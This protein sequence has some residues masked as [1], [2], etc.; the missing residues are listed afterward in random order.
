LSSKAGGGGH[1]SRRR[2][3][4]GE[5]V[6]YKLTIAVRSWSDGRNTLQ[7][8]LSHLAQYIGTG[9]IQF[10]DAPAT[11]E[12]Y[13]EAFDVDMNKPLYGAPKVEI[14]TG[15][16]QSDKRA[17]AGQGSRK[18]AELD[19]EYHTNAQT[20]ADIF[21]SL[22]R[23]SPFFVKLKASP[24]LADDATLL[25]L[26]HSLEQWAHPFAHTAL[27]LPT[28]TKRW[29]RQLELM[30][31]W[32]GR[33]LGIPDAKLQ[34]TDP[35]RAMLHGRPSGR[36]GESFRERKAERIKARTSRRRPLDARRAYSLV[37]ASGLLTTVHEGDLLSFIATRDGEK[38]EVEGRLLS[39][40]AGMVS[41]EEEGT[42]S[43]WRVPSRM[44]TLLST[45]AASRTKAE[46][47][48]ERKAML[49]MLTVEKM[50]GSSATV[51]IFR[52]VVK[53]RNRQRMGSTKLCVT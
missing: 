36:G 7:H 49:E 48:A 14:Q 4:K 17:A 21:V 39:V 27:K 18:H 25:L 8:E 2:T 41:L 22:Q 19:T 53:F 13:H 26:A 29:K 42:D 30:F 9:L 50:I 51:R 6:P 45:E 38:E 20:W 15:H 33:R 10:A 40:R 1:F 24:E 11:P 34:M 44:L 52:S 46:K 37:L 5:I 31:Q 23:G 32:V 35:L 3:P 16:R 12:G 28:N 47:R 43:T